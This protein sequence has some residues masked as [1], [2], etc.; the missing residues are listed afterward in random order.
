MSSPTR[1][2][3]IPPGVT[4]QESAGDE[5]CAGD[6]VSDFAAG[7]ALALEESADARDASVRVHAASSRIVA[8]TGVSI[9]SVRIGVALRSSSVESLASLVRARTGNNN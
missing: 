3:P 4:I 1:I 7:D 8:R 2:A 5:G 6:A 9:E